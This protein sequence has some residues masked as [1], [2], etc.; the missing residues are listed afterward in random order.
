VTTNAYVAKTNLFD[1]LVFFRDQGEFSDIP[2]YVGLDIAYAYQSTNELWSIYGGGVRFTHADLVEEGPGILV[3]EEVNISVYIHV[4][5]RPARPVQETDVLAAMIGA[6]IGSL[7]QA[8]PRL[9]GPFTYLRIE[10]GQGDYDVTNDESR[11][12]LAYNIVV[13]SRF[14]YGV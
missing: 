10:G 1:R 9:A 3:S 13:G 2:E 4:V 11:S 6:K 5:A 12:I 7:L 8:N 14:G